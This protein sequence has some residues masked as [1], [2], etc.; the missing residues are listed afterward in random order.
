MKQAAVSSYQQLDDA[1]SCTA[2]S[3]CMMFLIFDV[4]SVHVTIRR[5]HSK[6]KSCDC[7]GAVS[8]MVGLATDSNS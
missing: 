6:M 7:V 1:Y 5:R 2:S 3:C 4:D 8:C